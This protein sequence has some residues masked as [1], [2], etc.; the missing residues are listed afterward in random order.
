MSAN[1]SILV[2][3]FFLLGVLIFLHVHSFFAQQQWLNSQYMFNL[4]D[5]NI[6]YAGNHRTSSIAVRHRSQWIGVKGAPQSQWISWHSPLHRE[7]LGVGIQVQRESIGLREQLMARGSCAYKV[8]TSNGLLSFALAGA[9]VSQRA[10]VSEIVARDRVDELWNSGNLQSSSISFDA[11]FMYTSRRW[12]AGT[13]WQHLN[14]ARWNW[15]DASLARWFV[16]GTMVAGFYVPLANQHLLCF[17]ALARYQEGSLWQAEMHGAFYWKNILQCGLGYR[18]D[19][20]FTT[21]L[22]VQGSEH[23]RIGYSYDVP[24]GDGPSNHSGSHE[25]FLGLTIGSSPSPSIRYFQ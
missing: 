8:R 1:A 5:V 15:S 16:H 4:Y 11:G 9:F 19:N 3:R 17:S 23:L 13:E 21:F 24:M 14:R 25:L 20:G 10:D 2:K 7:R 6:A 12:F 18:L 22:Q